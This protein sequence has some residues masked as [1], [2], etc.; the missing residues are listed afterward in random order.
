MSLFFKYTAFLIYC[1]CVKNYFM[2]PSSSL[3]R[4][5]GFH[6]GNAGSS[7]A[8]VTIPPFA[9]PSYPHEFVTLCPAS[10]AVRI[11]EKI[12][13]VDTLLCSIGEKCN[14]RRNRTAT[15]HGINTGKPEQ[16]ARATSTTITILNPKK[17]LDH[18]P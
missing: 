18:C 8:G 16:W 12:S 4:T 11:G 10:V 2:S 17:S 1:R 14:G 5:P 7:P 6:P 13:P 9:T 3:V 15:H